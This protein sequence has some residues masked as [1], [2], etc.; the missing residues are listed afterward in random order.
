MYDS[1]K[2]VKYT[3]QLQNCFSIF[4]YIKILAFGRQKY[5]KST[6]VG[7]IHKIIW[8]I[9]IYIVYFGL[10]ITC[11]IRSN[12]KIWAHVISNPW[13][14]VISYAVHKHKGEWKV[15]F[16]TLIMHNKT[17]ISFITDILIITNAL[18]LWRNV[19]TL[20]HFFFNKTRL[21]CFIFYQ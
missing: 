19:V 5:S 4:A 8:W 11:F 15:Q 18:C 9:H 3:L 16:T 20:P 2:Y 13:Y 14:N 12:E 17:R 10:H 1:R 6:L 21:N 7:K